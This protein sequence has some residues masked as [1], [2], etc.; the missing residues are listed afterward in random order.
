MCQLMILY[1]IRGKEMVRTLTRCELRRAYEFV[2][3]LT[4][5]CIRMEDSDCPAKDLVPINGA[6]MTG[7]RLERH[8]C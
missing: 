2:Y 4:V 7:P 1:L 6:D 5:G 8:D 3:S